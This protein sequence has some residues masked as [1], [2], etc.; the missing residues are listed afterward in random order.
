MKGILDSVFKVRNE[1]AHGGIHYR[2]YEYIKLNGKEVLSQ[3]LYWEMKVIVSQLI[4][5]GINKLLK[6]KEIRNLSFKI[7]DLYDKIYSQ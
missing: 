4:I 1:I 5:L 7:D 2:G 3:D 6:N